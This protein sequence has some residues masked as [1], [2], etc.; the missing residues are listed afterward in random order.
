[1]LVVVVS[2]DHKKC[3]FFQNFFFSEIGGREKIGI[4]VVN[5]TYGL[6]VKQ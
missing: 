1:M 5:I 6:A 3:L 4:Y 2:G